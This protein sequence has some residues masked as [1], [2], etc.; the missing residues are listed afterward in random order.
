[1]SV[2]GMTSKAFRIL[3]QLD[4][5]NQPVNDVFSRPVVY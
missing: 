4:V 5:I 2:D 1:M 3:R